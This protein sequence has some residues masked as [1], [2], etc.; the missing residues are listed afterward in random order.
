MEQE[1]LG[2][3]CLCGGDIG[4]GDLEKDVALG[5]YKEKLRGCE[6]GLAG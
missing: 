4:A 6:Y 2:V 5:G 3:D 1:V